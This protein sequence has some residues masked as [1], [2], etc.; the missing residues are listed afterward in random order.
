MFAVSSKPCTRGTLAR[1]NTA[2]NGFLFFRRS[3]LTERVE[4]RDLNEASNCKRLFTAAHE[5]NW[6]DLTCY[7]STQLH[8]AFITPPPIGQ[9]SIAM[10]VSVCLS[11][12]D[13]VFGT[14][15]PISTEYFV[16]V[17][18]DRGHGPINR[19]AFMIVARSFSGGVLIYYVLPVLWV[20]LYLLVSQGC[21]TSPPS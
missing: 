12:R 17:T 6:P 2:S 3:P 5:L 4:L 20:T 14:T 18:Y 16:P 7:K 1:H 10:N 8:D 11:V 13:Y 19:K 9:R 15:R 21:S